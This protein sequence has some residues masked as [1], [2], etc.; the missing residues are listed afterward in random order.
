[1]F[2]DFQADDGMKFYIDLLD[3]TSIGISRGLVMCDFL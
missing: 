3:D 1:M 2:C